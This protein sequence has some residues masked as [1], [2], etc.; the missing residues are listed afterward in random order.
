MSPCSQYDL[1]VGVNRMNIA[2]SF[3]PVVLAL[4]AGC[5]DPMV[6]QPSPQVS[7]QPFNV[8]ECTVIKTN[9]PSIRELTDEYDWGFNASQ[10][11]KCEVRNLQTDST[12]GIDQW[13]WELL[14]EFAKVAIS[15]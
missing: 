8:E 10:L 4:V 9:R 7:Q 2:K 14:A 1:I 3:L 13:Y 12:G 15:Q 11:S 6:N 5:A